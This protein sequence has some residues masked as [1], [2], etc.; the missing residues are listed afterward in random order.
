VTDILDWLRQYPPEERDPGT[1]RTADQLLGQRIAIIE[2]D[3]AA[4]AR[5]EQAMAWLREAFEE[6][7]LALVAM[8]ERVRAALAKVTP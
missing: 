6:D 2:Q 3:Y 5:H 1:L 8:R 4:H 7:R